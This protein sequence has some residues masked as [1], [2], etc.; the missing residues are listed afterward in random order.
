MKGF[1]VDGNASL[2]HFLLVFVDQLLV[3]CED[4][5]AFV[6]IDH[7][8]VLQRRDDVILFD[9]SGFAQ[10]VDG[11]LCHILSNFFDHN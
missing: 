10:L 9:G 7:V 3:E 6:V 2:F 5:L 11:D 8:Q 1:W 4:V